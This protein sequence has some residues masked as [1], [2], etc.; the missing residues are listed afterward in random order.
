MFHEEGLPAHRA[1]RAD[2][3]HGALRAEGAEKKLN[4]EQGIPIS[5]HSSGFLGRYYSFFTFLGESPPEALIVIR[6]CFISNA[7]LVF[8]SGTRRMMKIILRSTASPT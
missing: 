1:L 6:P 8:Y 5:L 3:A 2:I 7:S 4:I